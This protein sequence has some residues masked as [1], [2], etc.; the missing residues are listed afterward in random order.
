M[1][2]GSLFIIT[3]TSAVG[4]TTV[5]NLVLKKIKNL[6]RSLTYTTRPLRAKEKDGKDYHFISKEEFKKKIKKSDF[7]EWANN[8]G[9]LYGTAK[10]EITNLL[11]KGKNVLINVD[12]KGALNI[13]KKWP[14]CITIFILPE[15]IK[16][17]ASRF[18]KRHDTSPAQVQKRLQIAQWE[19]AKA[20]QCDYWVIN[21]ENKIKQTVKETLEI[22]N[23]KT[24]TKS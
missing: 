23:S 2:K 24:L 19:L 14:N 17:L 18:K 4:K 20:P 21:R 5:A 16:Q 9:N 22:I 6:Q 13:K 11:K 7:L 3:G 10:R 8:Y 12:I 1:K 15:S